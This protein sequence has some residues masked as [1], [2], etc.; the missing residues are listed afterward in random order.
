MIN[1]M[2]PGLM[3][4]PLSSATALHIEQPWAAADGPVI[5]AM[6]GRKKAGRRDIGPKVAGRSGRHVPV[7]VLHLCPLIPPMRDRTLS[8]L[9][10]TTL[11]FSA[12]AQRTPDLDSLDHYIAR[13][14]KQ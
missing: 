14:V 12:A 11:A 3:S 2:M 10:A 4:K 5:S 8:L 9:I 6:A 7:A 1:R 13:A